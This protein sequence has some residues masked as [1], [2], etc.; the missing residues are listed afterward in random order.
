M[1]PS[2]SRLPR[3][4]LLTGVPGCG[5]TT[6]IRK[7]ANE[8]EGLAPAGFY[9]EEIRRQGQRRGFRLTGLN[10]ETSL[11]AH[12][13]FHGGPRVSRYGVDIARFED[14]LNNLKLD[15]AETPLVFIDEIGKMEC[16]SE[17]FIRLMRRLLDSQKTIVAT[18]ALKGVGFIAEVKQRSD[19]QLIEIDSRNRDR[20]AEEL[21][22]R[23]ELYATG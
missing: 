2:S 1:S 10:G 8:L 17:H 6:L 18:I 11:L 20:L 22:K 13:D 16:L 5:K 14:F 19:V 21:V 15:Q 3:H 9:T 12:V 4:I 23:I 7:L